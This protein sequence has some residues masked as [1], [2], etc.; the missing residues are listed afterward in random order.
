MKSRRAQITSQ[1]EIIKKNTEKIITEKELEERIKLSIEK[2]KPLRVKLGIDPTAQDIHLGFVLVLK[3][4]RDFQQLGHKVILVIGDFTAK[5][6]D[7]TGRNISRP[8]LSD[9]EIKTNMKSYFK[10]IFKVIDS[11]NLEVRYNSEWLTKLNFK[12]I[13]EIFSKI[14]LQKI[15]EREDFQ[16]RLRE[17]NPIFLNEIIYPILQAYD[18]LY[19]KSDIEIG[20]VDQELNCLM[21]RELQQKFNQQPQIIILMPLLIGLD[22]KNKMSKSLKNYIGISEPPDEI[23]GK[24]M[25]IPDSLLNQ[26]LNLTTNLT[27][28]EIKKLLTKHPMEIKKELGHE[29]IKQYYNEN[30]AKLA[31]K[32]FE[33]TFQ[34]KD[35]S[36]L[37]KEVVIP[38]EIIDMPLAEVLVNLNFV[39]SKSE[40]KRLIQQGGI[41][42]NGQK[43][44]SDD[45]KFVMNIN[46]GDLIRIGK[47][48]FFKLIKD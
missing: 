1:L 8:P 26:W 25:S 2:N 13:I 7:P 37:A 9:K 12:D 41:E 46:D 44:I 18:S 27:D 30:K 32:K 20:G 47:K 40:A 45:P 48:K 34:R 19:L 29:I 36:S 17:N 11:K 31:A 38:K 42:I 16:K 21:G 14:T 24:V 43:I 22:G 10:Q 39:N 6:G 3:K 15:T 23:F 35:Y 33:A 5:I 4:L 28:Q